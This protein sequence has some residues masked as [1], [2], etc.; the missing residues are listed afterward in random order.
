MISLT[1]K[2]CGRKLQVRDEFGGQTGK[3]PAC[4]STL[5]I[6]ALE[7]AVEPASLTSQV[8][9]LTAEKPA[10]QEQTP[11]P[12]LPDEPEGPLLN[13]GGGPLPDG[14]DFFAPAPEE[15]GPL[16]SAA[17][18]LVQG[19]QPTPM[20]S[21]LFGSILAIGL[22]IFVGVLIVHGFG[23]RSR[24]WVFCWPFVLA[25]IGCGAVI[26]MTG[27]S[28]TCTYVGRDGVARF[29]CSGSRDNLI[30][31]EVFRFREANDLRTATTLRY[32]NGAYQNT[33]YSYTWTDINGVEQQGAFASHWGQVVEDSLPRQVA[34]GGRIVALPQLVDNVLP[35]TRDGIVVG[36]ENM[37]HADGTY[38][39]APVLGTILRALDVPPIGG[40]TMFADMAA[41]YDNLDP[42]HSGA[43]RGPVG[44][45]RLECR[46][47]CR[48]VRGQLG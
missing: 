34:N 16:R 20:S 13:H 37:W 42:Q 27:F 2:S 48:Q 18:T 44:A 29:V 19:Q 9:E 32:V 4:G 46:K 45:A 1:C 5:E 23:V 17:T 47:L 35:F 38:R 12:E 14:A 40:D 41:A 8:S 30:S 11:P 10:Q 39:E 24:F 33:T 43:H 6:P 15:I 31:R 25:L 22:G 28:H 36:L 21:R 3:C 26:V 7:P